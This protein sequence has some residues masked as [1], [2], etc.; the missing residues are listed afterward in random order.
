MKK[1]MI[2][3][4]AGMSSSMIAKKSTDYFENIGIDIK[5]NA[6]GQMSV[7]QLVLQDEYDLYLISPQLRMFFEDLKQKINKINKNV[8]Q[9]PPTL[10]VSTDKSVRLLSQFIEN[11][12]Q[13]E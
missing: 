7:D 9:I 11:N 4:A 10:Y 13:G 12:L 1:V 3:C 2:I 5:V 6:R 8:V